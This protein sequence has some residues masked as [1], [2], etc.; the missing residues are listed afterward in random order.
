MFNTRPIADPRLQEALNMIKLICRESDLAGAIMLVN[1]Q[2]AAFTYPLYTTWNCV[3]E[4]HTLPLGF[5]FRLKTA[6]QGRERANQLALGT[7]HMLYQLQDF[8][9]QT[10]VWMGDLLA[11]LARA[12]LTFN[13]VP[14]N[15]E[16]LIR[17][18]SEP[19]KLL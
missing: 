1:E 6:E 7:G 15:G 2:E 3:V 19:P 13:H 18:T 4:D 12:G 16:R 5:R 17:L 10:W 14:F 9:Q 11:N 8:G